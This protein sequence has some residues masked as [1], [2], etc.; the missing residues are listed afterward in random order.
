MSHSAV[1][2]LQQP[3]W[4]PAEADTARYP[5]P[6]G[7]LEVDVAIVGAGIVGLTAACLLLAAGRKVAVFE[8]RRVGRQ[9]TG[10]STAKITSQH[11]KR[12]RNLIGNIGKSGARR[13]AAA[14][15]RAIGRIRN[16]CDTLELDC[17]LGILPAFVFTESE[18]H[19]AALREEADAAA[20]LGLPASFVRDVGLP[21]PVAGAL[22]FDDQSQFDPY[23]YLT[24]L[25]ATVAR[26]GLLFENTRVSG[27]EHGVPCKLRAGDVEVTAGHVIVA[28]QMP[29]IGD[30]LFFAKSFPIAH[31]MAAAPLPDSVRFEGMYISSGSPTHSFRIAEKDGQRFIVAVGGEYKTGV[32]EELDAKMNDLREFL[33]RAF[34][35]G[36]L[37]HAW[38]NEDFRPMDELP[39]IGPVSSSKPH[40][41]VA[42]GFD[43]WGMTQGTV[44]AEII[45]DKVL[46]RENDD[47][48]IFDASRVRP[49]AGG[50]E[51][52]T[53]NVKTGARLAGDRLLA[54]QV[55]SVDDIPEGQG[56]IV[57]RDGEQLAV[58][59]D[60]EDVRQALSAV[61]THLGCIVGWNAID[62]TWD[63]PCHGSRFDE[64]GQVLSGPALEPLEVKSLRTAPPPSAPES[65]SAA[66]RQ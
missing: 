25:A 37:S 15:E 27:V 3:F 5:A 31:P 19:V 21:F 47:A 45:S 29:V 58:V 38:V 46:G 34:G 64:Q 11:G 66:K 13:Y 55:Q 23:R 51:L 20:S 30:G 53:E 18:D 10:R 41:H 59:K 24:G 7:D 54:R 42:V 28:T 56:G 39:F 50:V 35:I 44:A 4:Y 63:C 52:I 48:E 22:R 62:R 32:P 60:G 17:G 49:V 9:A 65:D 8:A 6:D 2:E 36:Q 33:R 61:C 26:D 57:E 40:L 1:S 16:L 12:Y 14:N 43:A